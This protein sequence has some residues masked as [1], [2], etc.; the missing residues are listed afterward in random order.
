[1]NASQDRPNDPKIGARVIRLAQVSDAATALAGTRVPDQFN[2]IKE[3]SK[4]AIEPVAKIKLRSLSARRD[5]SFQNVPRATLH[6]R[7]SLALAM[8]S[9]LLI[10]SALTAILLSGQYT[11]ADIWRQLVTDYTS[12]LVALSSSSATGTFSISSELAS[13]RLIVQPSHANQGEPAPLGL[14]LQGRTDGAVIHIRRLMPGMELSTGSASGS[15]GWEIPAS[16]LDDVWVAPPEKFVGLVDLVTEVRLPSGKIV[17][18]QAIRLEWV[19]STEPARVLRHFKKSAALSSISQR[20]FRLQNSRIGTALLEPREVLPHRTDRNDNA[21][22][23][24]IS[25]APVQLQPARD[26]STPPDLPLSTLLQQ[27]RKEIGT[28]PSTLLESMQPQVHGG[29]TIPAELPTQLSQRQLNDDEIAVLLKRGKDLITAGDLSAARLVLRRA[30]DA[31]NAEAALA[32]AATYDPLVL[33]E[34]K[35]YRFTGDAAMARTWYEK[36]AQLGSSAAPRRLEML[37]E[38]TR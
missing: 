28:E 5:D 23:P 34:L 9:G 4:V 36:A 2:G 31:N 35:V 25:L 3:T 14:S 19:L 13:P 22:P 32:L 33:R 29:G 18:R 7:S 17:D 10:I 8:I 37:I 26:R 12:K 6:V 24:S 11:L 16:D 38:G 21:A 20:S 27:G 30:A 15:D 1:M